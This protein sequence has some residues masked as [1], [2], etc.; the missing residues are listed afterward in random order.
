MSLLTAKTPL[1]GRLPLTV[2]TV[3]A[4]EVVPLAIHAVT[5]FRGQEGAV[6]EALEAAA[7]VPL[8]APGRMA[9]AAGGARAL[10]IGPGQAL[11]LGM[12]GLDLPGAAVVDQSDAWAIAR[13]S[14]AGVEAVLARLVPLDLS[15]AAFAEGA[16]ARTLIGHMTGSVSRVGAE[17]FELMVFRSMAG[18]LVH[19][20]S[21]AMTGVA[22][23][24]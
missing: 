21:R 15:P 20:L 22:A 10:S 19:D 2:G 4:E 24:G 12:A 17:A 1:E 6:S 3:A 9:V 16:T 13:V 8:P 23:R 14:G 18:T 11:V 7:G 5:P